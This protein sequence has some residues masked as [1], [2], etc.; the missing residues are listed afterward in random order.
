MSRTATN[1]CATQEAISRPGR[2]RAPAFL[3][4][5]RWTASPL[6]IAALIGTFGL[7]G[8]QAQSL[9]YGQPGAHGA[10]A[11]LGSCSGDSCN[12]GHGGEGNAFSQSVTGLNANSI[13]ITSNGGDGGGGADRNTP[14]GNH[15]GGN[16]GG[17]AQFDFTIQGSTIAGADLGINATANGGQAGNWG[18]NNADNGNNAYGNGGD[19]STAR[20]TIS[21]SSVS[22]SATGISVSSQGAD[23]ITN[24]WRYVPLVGYLNHSPGNGGAGAS[25]V[26]AGYNGS[27]PIFVR[28]SG[29]VVSLSG[30]SVVTTNAA[31]AP[32]AGI[33]DG[34]NAGVRALSTGGRGGDATYSAESGHN[35]AGAGGSAASVTVSMDGGSV[36]TNG[37]NTPGILARSRGGD[38][39]QA[40]DPGSRANDGGSGGVATV[41][42]SGS[43]TTKATGSAAIV[44][45]SLGGNG[46]DDGGVYV[47]SGHH[48]GDGGAAL[49]AA[50]TNSGVLTTFGAYASGIVASVV[51]GTAGNGSSAE[52]S[53]RGGAGGVGGTLAGGKGVII[54]NQGRISTG[55]DFSFGVV[56]H[57]VGGG[58]GMGG[59]AIGAVVTGGI[60]GNGAVGGDMQGSNTGGIVTSGDH[61]SGLLLQ[62]IGGSGGVGGDADATGVIVTVGVGGRGGSGNHAGN[63]SVEHA[64]TIAT[65]GASSAGVLLQ[66]IGGGGGRAG[67]ANAVGV[68]IG[69]NVTVATGGSGGAAGN[70]GIVDFTTDADSTITTQGALSPGV[71]AQGIGGGGG[72]G[73]L[74]HSRTITIAP[75]TGDNPSGTVSISVSN[76]GTGRAGGVG[77]I[78]D[79]DS[80]GNVATSGAGSE[81]IIA[82]SIGGGGGKGGG[83][84]APIKSP[85]I[86]ASDLNVNVSVRHGGTGGAGGDANWVRLRNEFT[87]TVTTAGDGSTGLL[88]QSIGGGGG[89]GGNVQQNDQNSFAATFGSLTGLSGTLNSVVKYLES[90]PTLEFNGKSIASSITV[91][92]GGNGGA[93]GNG[94]SFTVFN[95]GSIRTSGNHASGIVAQSIGGGGGNAGVIDSGGVSSLLSSLDSLAAAAE[96]NITG[97]ASI[98]IPALNVGVTMGA[99]GGDGGNGG[100]SSANPSTVTNSGQISTQ[101]IASAGI[102]AQSIGGGGG[103]SG[104]GAQ[105]L[106]DAVKKAAPMDAA[107]I[108]DLITRI[109]ETVGTK[110]ESL[111]SSLVTIR[112]GGQDGAGGAG[113]AVTVDA[114]ADSSR[115]STAG[116]HSPG[117]LAQSIGGGGGVSATSHELTAPGNIAVDAGLGIAGLLY[118]DRLTAFSGGLVSV[119]NGGRIDTA[120]VNA[121]GIL[122]QSVGGGGG[123][124]ANSIDS[125]GAAATAQTFKLDLRL[126]GQLASVSYPPF[127]NV[128]AAGGAVSVVNSGAIA[129]AGAFSPSIVAQSVG[130]G[131]GV[132][133]VSS[134]VPAS[135]IG[136]RLGSDGPPSGFHAEG[137]VAGD[138]GSVDVSSAGSVTT[139]G[140]HGF[141][142]LAQSVGGGGGYVALDNGGDGFANP[143]SVTF[144]AANP[145][146]G[147]GGAVTVSLA[148]GSSIDTQG[149]NATAI[150]AQ[151]IGGGGGIAGLTTQ[152]GLATLAGLSGSNSPSTPLSGGNDG[153]D[154][155]VSVS[156]RVTTGGNGGIG[157]LAQSVGGGGGISGDM[158]SGQWGLNLI[159]DAGLTSGWGNGGAVSVTV[160]NGGVVQSQGAGTPAVLAMSVG[161]GGVLR[162]GV[163]YQYGT[164]SNWPTYGGTV[165]VNVG[166]GGRV[167]ARGANAPA[168][169]ALSNG[170]YGGGRGVSIA[171]GA[172]ATVEAD[173][174]SGTA[175]LAATP[176][177]TI[178]IANAGR[179]TAKTAIATTDQTRVDNSGTVQGD[180]TLGGGASVFNNNPGAN[181]WSGAVLKAT[182]V[183]NQGTLNPG[184]PNGYAATQMDGALFLSA[185]GTYAP[186]LDFTAGHSDFISVAGHVQFSGAIAPVLHNPVKGRW[187]GIGH[188]AQN[189]DVGTMPTLVSASPVFSYALKDNSSGWRDPLIAVDGNFTPAGV[190]LSR[191]QSQLAAHLQSQWNLADLRTGPFFNRF[192]TLS[193][194]AD[195][196][197]ALGALANDAA[198]SGAASQIHQSFAFL[199]SLMSCPSFVDGGTRL[200]EGDCV[201]GR[202]TGSRLERSGSAQDN[203][204]HATRTTYQVGAQKEIAPDWFL[205]GSLSYAAADMTADQHAVEISSQTVSAGLSL[206]R[207]LGP[208]LL[209]AAIRGGHESAD[210]TRWIVFPGVSERATSNPD[211]YHLGGRLRASYEFAFQRWY[212]RPFLDLDLNYAS[213]SAYREYGAGVLDL[214]SR[215]ISHT[216]VM[217]TPSIEIGGRFDLARATLRAY[218]IAGVSF[219]SNGDW[220]SRLQFADLSDTG[221][222]PFAVK[223]GMPKTY[224][225][226]TAGLEYL[227]KGG[228]EL[229]AEYGLR[230]ADRYLDQSA[231]LRAAMRF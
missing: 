195:Y 196:A 148:Q 12:G 116:A 61:S 142:I 105:T 71:L 95:A 150:L 100:G 186:D 117:I 80:F 221:V 199:N 18:A 103:S 21:N 33:G 218:A 203:G 92:H 52:F 94:N 144:G 166:S 217:S 153:G 156:G 30:V 140:A 135:H 34:T 7:G 39:G 211:T 219:L 214:A 27:I 231:M 201:W 58:G 63:L 15:W 77:G 110:G 62:S 181:L 179:I 19:G 101:G 6:A 128:A 178:T 82:Q 136:I 222:A 197:K 223:T 57:A 119:I 204:Y 53:G 36:T 107:A 151:S 89:S 180:V 20:L 209:A 193:S 97:F 67:S 228:F 220:T 102:V 168:I 192:T 146:Q 72:D 188:F 158:A 24:A 113:G 173:A 5:L 45:Q 35:R 162:D 174:V 55:G 129:T 183:N 132:A 109:A 187:M 56:A 224:G 73:G 213:Q 70:G 139:K 1:V 76:G 172:N 10:D 225:N 26:V 44:A 206:K 16:G 160:G 189:P 60:G 182:T 99:N 87:A 11:A 165:S 93:G 114:G 185:G 190:A 191:D 202:I 13:A 131:G 141:G 3:R 215:R 205:G 32:A 149:R 126:G 59:G 155:S 64:G 123:L 40:R 121:A 29:P 69:M 198:H 2:R 22:A 4:D 85:T 163:F 17:A 49:G 81:G 83:V 122:A 208:W 14:L 210:V 138:G 216:S 46:S 124:S 133:I 42:N 137:E 226:L 154:V 161:G 157:I 184:G 152:S 159:R 108:I 120:G 147:R 47:G 106:A 8:A 112:M 86:G 90:S 111:L 28:E 143:L 127:S 75:V 9:S 68:G 96:G 66:S 200:G 169:V 175:I 194:G 25:L 176:L 230:A 130:G 212:L 104:V 48:G 43:I 134:D 23:G 78:V 118:A 54:D 171:V 229:K 38:A 170:A 50:V 51:G 88:A 177:G 125:L 164:L 167:S 41:T 79:I 98:G 207:Q 115:I 74:A 37:A 84:L 145:V 65:N 227:T 31:D 91:T